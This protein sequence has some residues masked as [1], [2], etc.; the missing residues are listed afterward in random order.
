M[1]TPTPSKTCQELTK[2]Q[3]EKLDNA[4]NKHKLHFKEFLRLYNEYY[5]KNN[6]L[7]KPEDSS[8]KLLKALDI[9]QTGYFKFLCANPK[10][11]L[12]K[13]VI[14]NQ[15]QNSLEK[16]PKFMDLGS[17]L[18][19][20]YLNYYPRSNVSFW[21]N[22]KKGQSQAIQCQKFLNIMLSLG[23]TWGNN[24][25]L[26]KNCSHFKG[27]HRTCKAL[28]GISDAEKEMQ[29]I[30]KN[31]LKLA[32]DLHIKCRKFEQT[33]KNKDNIC[34]EGS[35]I[36]QEC[37]N[38]KNT[39]IEN[40]AKE[41]RTRLESDEFREASN[42]ITFAKLKQTVKKLNDPIFSKK[43][44]TAFDLKHLGFGH[45]FKANKVLRDLES[46]NLMLQ[47][48]LISLAEIDGLIGIATMIRQQKKKGNK[49]CFV[50]FA[51]DAEKP[52][53][54]LESA[55]NPLA[56]GN[57]VI[58]LCA[59]IPSDF[60][61][62][63]SDAKHVLITGPNGEGKSTAM[64]SVACC[65]WL[66]QSFG[67]APASSAIFSPIDNI[68]S[69][70]KDAESTSKGLSSHTGQL[71]R[72]SKLMKEVAIANNNGKKTLVFA[73]ELF[74]GTNST[75][76]AG[77]IIAAVKSISESAPSSCWLISSHSEKAHL[78]EQATSN[79]LK[80]VKVHERKLYTGISKISSNEKLLNQMQFSKDFINEYK[81]YKNDF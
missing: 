49:F 77:L 20:A 76:S 50:S 6:D 74:N 65:V 35:G 71:Y 64:R 10:I 68:C 46:C 63:T 17:F 29:E 72:V 21:E 36:L 53:I 58:D 73:D 2:E 22:A 75:D 70:P 3:R 33:N 56:K 8:N 38:L 45:L 51:K 13:W 66:G 52:Y 30:K 62:G 31:F 40:F 5:H 42:S 48:A 18:G 11:E 67:I 60:E 39:D 69:I 78:I 26:T 47:P 44:P 61:I 24:D 7:E 79:L 27:L 12:T 25:V 57:K 32:K 43:S 4:M 37:F 34:E 16:L 23:D 81:A 54:K 28:K 1:R 80:N 9:V 41:I 59:A 55:W 15:D 19:T 14:Q